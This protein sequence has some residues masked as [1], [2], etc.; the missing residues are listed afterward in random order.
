MPF[1]TNDEINTHLYGEVI[2]EITRG[3]DEKIQDA[4][5]AAVS[6]AEGYLT[7]YDTDAIFSATGAD[8]LPILLLYV[9]DITVWHFIQ[10]SNPGVDMELR[11][12]RYEKAIKWLERVQSGDVNPPLPLPAPPESNSNFIKA[13][14]NRKRHNHY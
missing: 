8:R 7:A 4:I 11:Q 1:L 6:E 14:G 13:G 10:L 5:E 9:K 12:T 3:D 2:D